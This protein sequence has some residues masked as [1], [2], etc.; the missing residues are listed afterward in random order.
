MEASA[1]L[2]AFDVEEDPLPWGVSRVEWIVSLRQ[3]L[4]M[5]NLTGY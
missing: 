4:S 3:Q 5:F 2:V 1:A